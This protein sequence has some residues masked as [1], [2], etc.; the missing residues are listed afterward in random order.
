[1]TGGDAGFFERCRARVESMDPLSVHGRV[2]SLVG[3]VIEAEGLEARVGSVCRVGTGEPLASFDAE[4]IGFRDSRFVLMPLAGSGGVAPGARVRAVRAS[5]SVRAGDAWLGRVVDGLG[6]PLDGEPPPS[7]E[8]EVPLYRRS[9]PPLARLPVVRPLDVGVRAING[10][11][12]LGCGARMGIFAGSGV[13]KSTLLGQIARHT[14]ADVTVIALVGERGRE[15]REFVERDLGPSL[16]RCTVVVATSD[17]PPLLRVRAAYVATALAEHYRSKGRHVLLLMDS[18][19]RFCTALREIGLAVGEPPATRG[20]PP[21]MWARLPRLVER[22]GNDPCGGSITGIYTVLMEGDDPHEPVVDAARSLLDG[23]V[24]LSRE[25]AEGG[26]F[27]PIDVLGSVSR[28]MGE[29]VSDAHAGLAREA[30]ETLATYRRAEDL[31]S[32]GA[33]HEGSDDAIDR[34][35]R[36]REPLREFLRQGIGESASL[37]ESEAALAR[38]LGA[39]D[40]EAA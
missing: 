33:Y 31:I 15:V 26:L 19:T 30:R 28:V 6:Q 12:T 23:H 27:P 14:S 32:I 2:C 38:V 40:A 25:L 13:G 22:A 21:S 1:M 5:A 16:P 10:L 9:E 11:V 37:A 7:A 3:D 17:E 24:Q 36:L 35:R 4:V 20:Y 29:V 8:T 18:L 34:A 39:A